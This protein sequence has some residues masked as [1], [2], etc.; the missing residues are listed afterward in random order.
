MTPNNNSTISQYLWLSIWIYD[1]LFRNDLEIEFMFQFSFSFYI[2]THFGFGFHCDRSCALHSL[3]T[4][5]F[6]LRSNSVNHQLKFEISLVSHTMKSNSGSLSMEHMQRLANLFSLYTTIFINSLNI[7]KVK[8][9][10][11]E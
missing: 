6:I 4:V 10:I 3:V 9:F 2:R 7:Q 11:N 1:C 8:S 5:A